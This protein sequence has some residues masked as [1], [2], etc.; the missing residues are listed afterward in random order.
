MHL[1]AAELL[2]GD[3]LAGGGLHQRG[4]A[5]EDRALVADDDGLVAHRGDVGAPGRAGSEDGGD[6]RDPGPRHPGLVVEDPPEVL[7]VREDLVLHRQE[8]AAGVHQVDA[9]Q[10]VVERDLLCAQVLLHR[11]RVVRAALDGGVVGDD[12]ALAPAHPPDPG[13]DPGR[14]GLAVVQPV[15]GERGQLQ[16]GRAGV[17]QGV[18]P[19]PGQQ[20]AARGVP[21]ARPLAAAQPGS[22]ELVPQL[23][24][25]GPVGLLVGLPGRRRGIRRARQLGCLIHVPRSPHPVIAC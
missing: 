12:H 22:G 4:A 16:E 23:V 3:D 13:D 6:L 2:G 18:D 8:G 14:R 1:A 15:G 19:V 9:R 10:A 17:E 20:L 24:H 21:L 7:A 5:E 11:H 25:E